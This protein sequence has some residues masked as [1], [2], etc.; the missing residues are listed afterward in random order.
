MIDGEDRKKMQD[1]IE[2]GVCY[3]LIF[4][5]SRITCLSLSFCKFRG[6]VVE[7]VGLFAGHKLPA[8]IKARGDALWPK[9]LRARFAYDD[10][11]KPPYGFR[12]ILMSRRRSIFEISSRG[13]CGYSY[14]LGD[15]VGG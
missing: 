5:L 6:E 9:I 11:D 7:V 13:P 10:E 12:E 15:V 1:K 2:L 3:G 14:H 4:N 8:S